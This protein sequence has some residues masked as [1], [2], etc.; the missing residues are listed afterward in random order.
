[1]KSSNSPSFLENSTP[2]KCILKQQKCSEEFILTLMEGENVSLEVFHP[3]RALHF[4]KQ[5][6]D[7]RKLQDFKEGSF[8]D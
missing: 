1:M 8:M 2:R 5:K 3:G 4:P 7:Q 6:L